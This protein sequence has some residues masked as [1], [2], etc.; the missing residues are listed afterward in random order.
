MQSLTMKHQNN[1]LLM[2]A[3]VQQAY[4]SRV[5]PSYTG[6][7]TNSNTQELLDQTS[8]CSFGVRK[9]SNL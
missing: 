4:F 8:C 5:T 1:S 7:V 9:A 6:Q 2:S 3:F